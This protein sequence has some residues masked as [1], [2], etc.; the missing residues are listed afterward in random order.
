MRGYPVS[1]LNLGLVIG[2]RVASS[3]R[4]AFGS[5]QQRTDSLTQSLQ[6]A[7]LGSS[8]TGDLNRYQNQLRQLRRQAAASGGATGQ[9]ARQIAETERR[10]QAAARRA[11]RYGLEVGNAAR[12]H[13]EFAA[14]VQRSERALGRLNARQRNRDNR[15]EMLGQGLGLA[16]SGYGLSRFFSGQLATESATVRLSTVLNSDDLERDLGL[17]VNH[18]IKASLKGLTDDVGMLNIQYAL[19]SAGFEA[20]AARAG[21]LVVSK[22]ATVTNGAPEA[23]G[24]VVATVFNNL[25]DSLEGTTQERVARIGDLLTKTQFKFQ[26]KDFAQLGES[27]K[28]ASPAL[29]QYNVDLAQGVTL[30]GALNSAGLQGSMAGTSLSATFRNLSKAS[31]SFGFD[32]ARN[33]QGQLDFIA[34]MEA[35]RD[36]IGGFD[37][38]DQST[39]D[40]LQSVFGDEGMRGVVLLGGQLQGLRQAQDDVAESSRGIVDKSYERFLRSTPGQLK[41]LNHNLAQLT[42]TAT[43][44]LLPTVNKLL[45]AITET[46]QE[47]GAV[48]AQNPDLI[49]GAASVGAAF[50]GLK[51]GSIVARSG[52]TLLSD[53]GLLLGSAFDGIKRAA[54]I[55]ARAFRTLGLSL[56]ASPVG[57][58]AAAIA[59]A[60]WFIW[61][62]WDLVKST[63]SGVWDGFLES[64]EPVEQALEPLQPAFDLV[65]TAVGDFFGWISEILQPLDASAESLQSAE[66][67]GKAFGE[68][69]GGFVTEGVSFLVDVLQSLGEGIAWIVV[70]AGK[71]GKWLGGAIFDAEQAIRGFNP[72]ELIENAWE[73][74]TDWLDQFSLKDF[75]SRIIGS[76]ADGIKSGT[77][78]LLNTVKTSLNGLR[79][80]LPFSDAK[81]GPLSELTTSGQ[82]IVTTLGEGVEKAGSGP[83]RQPLRKAVAAAGLGLA[84]SA[85]PLAADTAATPTAATEIVQSVAASQSAENSPQDSATAAARQINVTVNATFN[86]Q[87]DSGTD[88]LALSDE[89]ESRMAEIIRRAV[90]EASSGENDGA[91]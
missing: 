21:S 67:S 53:G 15:R 35:L 69:L 7:R 61:Q 16:A 78:E 63:L 65:A 42:K 14:A 28:Y 32:L 82:A 27:M 23:V 73:S 68:I 62:N 77:G 87:N 49:E 64:T 50:L 71:L 36:S 1:D 10:Y 72:R 38:I 58:A 22:V 91:F 25:G 66:K 88:T 26:I 24:E 19:N 76:L 4:G 34:T 55:A 45:P 3:V 59:A 70:E 6:R 52:Y 51:A 31:R 33:S 12:Q 30:I 8:L 18:A 74:V 2:A 48:I 5:I 89:L 20:A 41:I 85:P 54:P 17:S 83:I 80:Y 81:K 79:E 75:G 47:F 57:A 86:I 29:A 13:R 37:N 39:L 60:G 11:S 44:S 90:I 40:E 43:K 84:V 9:L 46:V 56:L